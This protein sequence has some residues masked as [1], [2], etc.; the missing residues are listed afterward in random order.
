MACMA[1]TGLAGLFFWVGGPANLVPAAAQSTTSAWSYASF[2]DSQ[3]GNNFDAPQNIA[4]PNP[5]PQPTARPVTTQ[6]AFAA[7]KTQAA[8]PAA[9]QPVAVTTPASASSDWDK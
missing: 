8:Q 6:A 5:T 1:L 7:P 3:A 4:R 2:Y 9:V